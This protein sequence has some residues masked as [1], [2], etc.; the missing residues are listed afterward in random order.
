MKQA[1][2][3][4]ILLFV[5]TV[6][7]KTHTESSKNGNS[8]RGPTLVTSILN[9]K[10][11]P[12]YV[13]DCREVAMDKVT[14]MPITK[15]RCFKE[16]SKEKK[17]GITPKKNVDL[18]ERAKT[19]KFKPKASPASSTS[20]GIKCPKGYISVVEPEFNSKTGLHFHFRCKKISKDKK[21]GKN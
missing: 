18:T 2:I 10:C 6:Q 3:V 14:R 5:Y 9:K 20:K 8:Y 7:N 19:E 15:C 11:E 17:V 13:F 21:E 12:G 1:L 16:N 4:L